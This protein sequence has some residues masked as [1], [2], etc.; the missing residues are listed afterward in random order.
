MELQI[1]PRDMLW[2]VCPESDFCLEL[3]FKHGNHSYC[4]AL[5]KKETDSLNSQLDRF[6]HRWDEERYGY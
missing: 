2:D 4:I 5:T 1:H 3:E 6:Y